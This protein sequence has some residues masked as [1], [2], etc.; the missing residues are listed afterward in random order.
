MSRLQVTGV[1][2]AVVLLLAPPAVGGQ[3]ATIDWWSIDGGGEVLATGG[4]WTLSGSL[5]QW[6]STEGHLLTG[7]AWQMTGGFWAATAGES[8]HV[9]SDGFES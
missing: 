6:D 7:G 5:G 3:Q 1:L 8:A 2:A 9:F 4:S